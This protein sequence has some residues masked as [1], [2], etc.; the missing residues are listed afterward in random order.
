[1]FEPALK[2]IAKSDRGLRL[3]FRYMYFA[4]KIRVYLLSK[5]HCKST[6]HFTY[7]RCDDVLIQKILQSQGD[8]FINIL[9][10]LGIRTRISNIVRRSEFTRYELQGV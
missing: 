10:D 3:L 4:D 7:T 8:R 2:I 1:M 9:N 6:D 5:F